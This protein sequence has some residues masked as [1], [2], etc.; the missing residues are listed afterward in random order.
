LGKSGF[1]DEAVVDYLQIT[2]G[3]LCGELRE[4]SGAEDRDFNTRS[5]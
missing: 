2:T 3:E 5:P 4:E 1:G